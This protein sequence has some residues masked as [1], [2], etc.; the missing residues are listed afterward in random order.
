[1]NRNPRSA[2]LLLTGFLAAASTACAAGP[3]VTAFP[4][5]VPFAGAK[6]TASNDWCGSLFGTTDSVASEFSTAP[7]KLQVDT[8]SR[9]SLTCSYI[10]TNPSWDAPIDVTLSLTTELWQTSTSGPCCAMSAQSGHVYAL[11]RTSSSA[12]P[13]TAATKTWLEAAAARAT[14]PG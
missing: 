5:F 8:A 11:A 7:L 12:R 3:S 10:P 9:G 14:L 4:H 2:A 1:M 13:M 6:G